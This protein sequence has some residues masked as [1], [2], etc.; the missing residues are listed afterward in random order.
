MAKKLETVS[1][2]IKKNKCLD[3]KNVTL[4]VGAGIS[5][6]APTM[7][8]SGEELTEFVLDNMIIGKDRFKEIWQQI[9]TYVSQ[10]CNIHVTMLPR[11]E[12]LLSSIAYIEKYFMGKGSFKGNFLSGLDA[13]DKVPFNDNHLLLAALVHAGARVM[14]ANFDLGIE[15]AYKKLYDKECTNV[16]HFHGTNMSGDKIGATIENITHFVNSTMERK[17]KSNFYLGKSNYF[18]G[19]SFSDRYDVNTAIYE[20]YSKSGTHYTKDNYVCNHMGWDKELTE[21]VY[22]SFNGKENVLINEN[23]TTDALKKLCEQYAIHIPYQ[24]EGRT[25]KIEN[26]IKGNQWADIFREKIEISEE[27]K[28]LSSIHFYNRMGI[29]IDKIDVEILDKY[30]QMKFENEKKEILEYHLAKNCEYWYKKY[31]D[32]RLKT[33]YHK[34]A[35]LRRQTMPKLQKQL[36]KE[37]SVQTVDNIVHN[38]KE[39]NFIGYEDF[40]EL[41]NRVNRIKFYLLTDKRCIDIVSTRSLIEEFLKYPVGKFIEIILYACTYRYKM[42]IDGIIGEKNEKYFIRSNE[43]YYDIGSVDGIVSTQ[44]DYTISHYFENDSDSWTQI[45]SMDFWE[46]LKYLCEVTGNYHY[47]KM[48]KAIETIKR[49]K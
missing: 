1:I 21:K 4:W 6:K 3:I 36:Q 20:L 25:G 31:G 22:S 35:L 29:A 9:N 48:I 18:F 17:I 39:R 32:S 14:T 46:K 43:I 12:L 23:E 7:L 45:F 49:R 30:E 8:P 11:L 15:R 10:Y 19:Y 44:L 47:R 40:N 41:S 34:I 2:M 24:V 5:M 27:F 13:F 26:H 16:I 33:D 28:I 38:V 42:L 37:L